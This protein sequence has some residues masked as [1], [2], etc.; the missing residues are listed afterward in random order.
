MQ[1]EGRQYRHPFGMGGRHD[2]RKKILD[3][4]DL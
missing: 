4:W 2:H 1:I 3:D